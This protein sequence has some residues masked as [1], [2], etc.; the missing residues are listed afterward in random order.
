MSTAVR[1]E[2]AAPATLRG[3]RTQL[4]GAMRAEWTKVRTVSGPGWLLLAIVALTVP[5]ST[6]AAAATSCPRGVA[7]PVDTTKLS[8][9]GIQFGQAVVAILA[10]QAFCNEYSTGMIRVTFAALPRRETVLAAKAIIIAAMVLLA[11]AVAVLGSVLAGG[12]ILPGHG[13]T[14]THGFHALSLGYGPTLRAAAGSVLY[15]AL[16]ALLGVG[17]AAAIRDSALTIGVVLALLYLFPIVIAFVGSP[18]WQRRIQRYSPMA[19]I[20]I[21][22]TTGLKSLAIAPWAGLGVLAIWA[23][24]ALVGGGLMVRMRDA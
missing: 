3:T 14:A 19:G 23:A 12:L 15:L 8:L 11:G 22:A 17:V 1:A 13:F 5:V 21:Q 18:T 9:T 16:V 20:N 24:V 2:Q 4:R 10:V 7:C 6:A